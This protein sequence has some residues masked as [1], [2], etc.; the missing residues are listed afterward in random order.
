MSD[1]ATWVVAMLALAVM[2]IA[3][4]VGLYLTFHTENAWWLFL[5]IPVLAFIP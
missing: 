3:P 5:C 2:F 1:K 4:P